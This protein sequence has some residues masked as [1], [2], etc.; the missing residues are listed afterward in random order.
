MGNQEIVGYKKLISAEEKAQRPKRQWVKKMN[1]RLKGFRISPSR[2]LNWKPFSSV[3]L[4]RKMA[5]IY[6]QIVKRMM[7][8][9]MNNNGVCPSF[10]FSCHWGLPVLSH[11]SVNRRKTRV[12]A[13]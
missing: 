10:I 13:K 6:T 1:G 8:M 3:W 9:K 4:P 7:K 12:F 11:P 2:K 5:R